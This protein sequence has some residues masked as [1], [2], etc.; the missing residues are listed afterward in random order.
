V[1]VVSIQNW[2]IASDDVPV[3]APYWLTSDP[4]SGSGNG[5][6]KVLVG[7]NYGAA[8]TGSL[9]VRGADGTNAFAAGKITVSQGA[10]TAVTTLLLGENFTT[11]NNAAQNP[12]V[13]DYTTG[14]QKSGKGAGIVSYTGIATD[15][16]DPD[17]EPRIRAATALYPSY[18]YCTTSGN[19]NM[20]FLPEGSSFIIN[21]IST[22][23]APAIAFSFGCAI[24]NAAYSSADSILPDV[25]DAN[26]QEFTNDCLD[27]E[28]S[29]SG[30]DEW[31]TINYHREN[32]WQ[33]TVG[34]DVAV[35]DIVRDNPGEYISIRFTA[36]AQ[37]AVLLDDIFVR[38]LS[39][40]S[41][42]DANGYLTF[43]DFTFTPNS[44]GTNFIGASALGSQSVDFSD[45]DGNMLFTVTRAS[46]STDPCS[47]TTINSTA[48]LRLG[49][50]VVAD[51]GVTHILFTV[52]LP[53]TISGS[54][55]AS[56]PIHFNNANNG[57]GYNL[58]YSATG[59]DGSWT[60]VGS[61]VNPASSSGNTLTIS[62][63]VDLP[64]PISDILYLRITKGT[65]VN[66][67]ATT[68]T[69]IVK[70]QQIILKYKP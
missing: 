29:D 10:V 40:D 7:F 44:G 39:V 54:L 46:A 25:T 26:T 28:W 30:T 52:Y 69:F 47:Y 20:I 21:Q 43:L 1:N 67:T 62:G 66:S 55:Q 18:S 38:S 58:D 48:G 11:G 34:W 33:S 60:T 61:V 22:A 59:D 23:S 2:V 5:A 53:Q 36:H 14:F 64:E 9:T 63:T 17:S 37:T 16:A 56:A 57:G 19:N 32:A 45:D 4:P 8:R 13:A 3:G 31:H 24:G 35:A 12:K 70:D 65:A 6:I 15:S 68:Q 50:N 51:Q 42:P 49:Q 27:V 41:G